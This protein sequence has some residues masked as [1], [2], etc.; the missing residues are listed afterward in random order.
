MKLGI[1]EE[2]LGLIYTKLAKNNQAHIVLSYSHK[3]NFVPIILDNVNKK[4][5]LS[6]KE[7]TY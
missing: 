7:K 4:L 3:P 5:Q 2:K 6:T 1:K